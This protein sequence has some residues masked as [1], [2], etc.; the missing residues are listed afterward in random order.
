MTATLTSHR[1]TQPRPCARPD[2][3][4][5]PPKNRDW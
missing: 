4:L 5:I 1:G 2:I 3:V